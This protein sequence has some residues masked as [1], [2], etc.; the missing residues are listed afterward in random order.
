MFMKKSGATGFLLLVFILMACVVVG[1]FVG[2]AMVEVA[3]NN[4]SLGFLDF[5][6]RG[7]TFGLTSP[8]TL[9]LIAVSLTFG[10]SLKFSIMSVLFMV[11]GVFIFR[12][13]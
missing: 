5:L 11:L 9:D 8:V 3:A 4:D 10:V 7:H 12:K 6:G 13:L 2:E 1:S